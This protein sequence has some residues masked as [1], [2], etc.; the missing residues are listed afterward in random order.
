MQLCSGTFRMKCYV[1]NLRD[2]SLRR[3]NQQLKLVQITR[4]KYSAVKIDQL[5]S[6]IFFSSLLQLVFCIVHV[7][8]HQMFYTDSVLSPLQKPSSRT[9]LYLLASPPQN[10]DP[11]T[12]SPIHPFC[13]R[14]LS[15]LFPIHLLT[16]QWC[17]VT[18]FLTSFWTS[19]KRI[20]Q[21]I[22]ERNHPNLS[23]P[24]PYLVFTLR[25][26]ASKLLIQKKK[27]HTKLQIPS[28][29]N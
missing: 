27:N 15:S 26:K 17:V 5:I 2:H 22:W 9:L 21:Y 25:N 19:K 29:S 16:N 12:A 7:L 28:N 13:H 18:N 20:R 14:C 10:T 3:E 11:I 8:K 6:T 24:S 1:K 4:A 23:F